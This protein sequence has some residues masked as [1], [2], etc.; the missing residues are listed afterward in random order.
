MV[1]KRDVKRSIFILSLFMIAGVSWYFFDMYRA[2]L[3]IFSPI[4]NQI[5]TT[6]PKPEETTPKLFYGVSLDISQISP[7]SQ[8]YV[9][10][11]KGEDLLDTAHQ[12]GVNMIRITNAG[13]NSA[14]PDGVYTKKDW[15]TILA[16]AN[17]YGI[18][19]VILIEFPYLNNF[20]YSR[21]YSDFAK[22]YVIDSGVL[23][24]PAVYAVDVRNEPVINA[25]SLASMKSVASMIKESY[26]KMLITIGGWRVIDPKPD[27]G[28]DGY[29][30]QEPKAGEEIYS[31][32]DYY[33]M[34]LYG[35]DK[36]T[37]GVYPNPYNLTTYEVGKITKIANKKPILIE[38][39]GAGNGDA[40]TD[41]GTLGSESM[42]ANSY[43]GVYESVMDN[44]ISANLLGTIAY[45][46]YPRDFHTNGWNIVKLDGSLY[47][48]A[49]ILKKYATG[50]AVSSNIANGASPQSYILTNN[51]FGKSIVLRTGDVVGL[52]LDLKGGTTNYL[53]ASPSSI[54]L[55]T[56]RLN[57]SPIDNKYHSV[58]KAVEKGTT[59]IVQRSVCTVKGCSEH[60]SEENY[61]KIN[62]K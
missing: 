27:D 12:L 55:Q 33:S 30:W 25:I 62:V 49:N 5:K 53:S 29:I 32:V 52:E 58:F 3:A 47:P 15:D 42:Q 54:L 45:V 6:V 17:N 59:T 9:V 50:K 10:N 1:I 41:Q 35:F 23:D 26:P 39:F 13:T 57:Y 40:I 2:R 18:K 24:N 28:G 20:D 48:S 8:R 4:K 21:R 7:T 22:H 61:I 60:D 46:F 36:K 16:K 31:I 37:F 38:E 19:V 34:H 11:S 51:S 56:E 44:Q 14:R 43:A